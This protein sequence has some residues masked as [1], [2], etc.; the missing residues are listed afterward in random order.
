MKRF[1]NPVDRSWGFVHKVLQVRTT[2]LVAV[3]LVGRGRKGNEVEGRSTDVPCAGAVR[4]GVS[5]RGIR[6]RNQSRSA[7]RRRGGE[8][9]KKCQVG[10]DDRKWFFRSS[11][12]EYDTLILLDFFLNNPRYIRPSLEQVALAAAQLDPSIKEYDAVIIGG[13]H[14]GLTT[15][16]YLAKKGGYKNVL[17]LERRH[18][19]GGA[20]VTEEMVPGFKFSR[21]AYLAGLMRPGVIKDLELEKHGKQRGGQGVTRD[22]DLRKHGGEEAG[23]VLIGICRLL[24]PMAVVCF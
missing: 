12:S 5:F 8:A 23:F 21:C 10:L 11:S 19:V 22:L 7:G 16:A 18:C 4:K 1:T 3:E 15:A 24:C 2:F 14:N 6:P 9:E 13:G 20:A 17:V